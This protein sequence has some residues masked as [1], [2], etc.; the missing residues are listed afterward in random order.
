ML[1]SEIR[2][3]PTPELQRLRALYFRIEQRDRQSR[4]LARF[5]QLDRLAR[6]QRVT[7]AQLS[8]H[9]GEVVLP[10]AFPHQPD[11]DTFDLLTPR[12]PGDE[13]SSNAPVPLGPAYER[14]IHRE[15]EPRP[16]WL[17]P[18]DPWP[19]AAR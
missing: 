1:A 13:A 4:A 14:L 5:D 12:L 3:F 7:P 8:R 18:D 11:F 2:R 16:T 17:N 10:G 9:F 6:S 15:P 19:A